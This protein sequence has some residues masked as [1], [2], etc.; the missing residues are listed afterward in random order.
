MAKRRMNMQKRFERDV[1]KAERHTAKME[2]EGRLPAIPPNDYKGTQAAWM[3]GL[4]ERGLWDGKR[5]EFHGDVWLTQE[6]Y[7]ALL[8]ACEAGR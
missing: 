4:M 5:P 7:G 6:Q 2:A 1:A 8:D 3:V